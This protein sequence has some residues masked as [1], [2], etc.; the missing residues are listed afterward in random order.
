MFG[1]D[2]GII[3]SGRHRM[4][5]LDLSFFVGQQIRF[6]ALK[7]PESA[8]LEPRSVFA[9]ADPFATR[10]HPNHRDLFVT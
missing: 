1:S 3:E 9:A 8:G 2:R 4:G 10:F 7:D 5:E 6:G